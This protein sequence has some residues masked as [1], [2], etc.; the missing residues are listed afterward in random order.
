HSTFP[1]HIELILW[2]ISS[3]VLT[4]VPTFMLLRTLLYRMWWATQPGTKW[5]RT[6]EM[7]WYVLEYTTLYPGCTMYVPARFCVLILAF[8]T[9]HDLPLIA[10]SNISWATYIPHL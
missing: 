10:F 7:G 8:I 9:L 6:T 2:R 4:V 3:V 5:S 1:T